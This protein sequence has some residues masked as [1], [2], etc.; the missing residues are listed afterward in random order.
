MQLKISRYRR[1]FLFDN[2]THKI[3]DSQVTGL[4]LT[5][6]VCASIL[7]IFTTQINFRLSSS[8][9]IFVDIF[10]YTILS[11]GL[12]FSAIIIGHNSWTPYSQ[13]Y[14]LWWKKTAR[15]NIINYYFYAVIFLLISLIVLGIIDAKHCSY[16]PGNK[17][18]GII[19]A[20]SLSPL[21]NFSAAGTTF[22]IALF[23][24]TLLNPFIMRIFNKMNFEGA[25]IFV[26]FLIIISAFITSWKDVFLQYKDLQVQYPWWSNIYTYLR[27]EII[28]SYLFLGMYIRKF[29][30]NGNWKIYLSLYVVLAVSLFI[31]ETTLNQVLHNNKFYLLMLPGELVS[32]IMIIFIFGFLSNVKFK[33][34]FKITIHHQRISWLNNKI[35]FLVSDM[36]MIILPFCH[37]FDGYVIGHFALHLQTLTIGSNYFVLY[38][39]TTIFIPEYK[40]NLGWIMMGS[41]LIVAPI[42]FVMSWLKNKFVK[43]INSLLN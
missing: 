39:Q 12:P 13:K 16:F 34:E 2:G 17:Y 27:V 11:I 31:I 22:T 3:I 20:A 32:T 7:F 43:K 4:F 35:L 8:F 6:I 15:N 42:I 19:V 26:I 37:Y 1:N 21:Q 38:P 28:F 18:Y 5:L 29:I 40:E 36:Y 23:W 30:K 10:K 25:T 24:F 9:K 33:H 41:S 14:S